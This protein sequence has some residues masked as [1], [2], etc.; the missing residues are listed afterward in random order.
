MAF[1]LPRLGGGLILATMIPDGPPLPITNEL[2]AAKRRRKFVRALCCVAQGIFGEPGQ[3][4]E[5]LNWRRIMSIA[6]HLLGVVLLQS[7]RLEQALIPIRR[8]IVLDPDR[9]EVIMTWALP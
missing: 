2:V 3:Y 9:A 1:A 8:A 7:G 4:Q 6:L 5:V